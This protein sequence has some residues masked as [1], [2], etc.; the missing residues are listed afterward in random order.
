MKSLL[1]FYKNLIYIK[2]YDII[3]YIIFFNYNFMN[4]IKLFS[5]LILSSIFINS[6]YAETSTWSTQTSSGNIVVETSTAVSNTS[7]TKILWIDFLDETTI[8]IKLSDVSSIDQNNS[9]IKIFNDLKSI[10]K[11][12]KD[13]TIILDLSTSL[14][15]WVNYS[16]VSVDPSLEANMDFTYNWEKEINNTETWWT[17][18]IKKSI[19]KNDNTIELEFASNLPQNIEY[20][21]LKEILISEMVFNVDTLSIKTKEPLDSNNEYI[22]I[23]ILK[24][25]LGNDIEMD[26]ES[27]MKKFTT[28]QFT[29]PAAV[30][31]AVPEVVSVAE[32][33]NITDAWSWDIVEEL[34]SKVKTNPDTWSET[35]IIAIL[36][37][38][39]WLAYYIVIWRN[40]KIV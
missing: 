35:T 18:Y 6:V 24:D 23:S 15:P 5:F 21:V 27:S 7:V 12:D 4:N 9:E 1:Y 31:S 39:L 26:S 8:N 37:I 28:P 38:L 32:V 29:I 13:N 30:E 19:F 25:N 11:K 36:A 22:I 33:W 3:N 2:K 16:I 14:T 20:K 17:N 34:A 10:S 40:K